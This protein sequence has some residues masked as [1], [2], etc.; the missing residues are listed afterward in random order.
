MLFLKFFR[1]LYN[2]DEFDLKKR[3]TRDCMKG[4]KQLPRKKNR[5]TNQTICG[6]V[7]SMLYS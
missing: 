3:E 5:H 4:I 6:L 2:P 7:E 1:W